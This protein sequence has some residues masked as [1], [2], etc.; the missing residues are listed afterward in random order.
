MNSDK[1]NIGMQTEEHVEDHIDIRKL[2]VVYGG[3][4]GEERAEGSTTKENGRGFNKFDAPILTPI[5]EDYECQGWITRSQ[6]EE[7]SHRIQKYHAQWEG[8]V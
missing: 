1:R 7:V 4:T 5:A 6:L 2:M 3:Q 8:C